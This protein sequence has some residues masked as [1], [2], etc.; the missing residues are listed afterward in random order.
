VRIGVEIKA[1][2]NGKTG[3]ARYLNEILFNLQSI[4]TSNE[5]FLF[6]FSGYSVPIMNT[7]WKQFLFPIKIPGILW[8][9]II[10]PL[11]CVVNKI[12]VLWAPEQT[13]P[14]LCLPR[15]KIVTT[16][17]DFTY[18][19]FPRTMR[20][21]NF[22]IQK[23]FTPLSCI[24]SHRIITVS[25]FVFKELSSFYPRAKAK[26]IDIPNGKPDWPMPTSY[27]PEKRKD[28]L[29]FN[30]NLEPRKNLINLLRAIELIKIKNRKTIE[31]HIAG[32][33]GWKQALFEKY[34]NDSPIRDNIRMLGF[35]DD[36]AL[37]SEYYS[38]KALVYPSL[39]EGFGLPVLEAL[40]CDCLV[41][42]S[43]GTVM[44]E[45]AREC[46]LYFNPDD[47]GDIAGKI[48]SL[49]QPGFDRALFLAGK[50]RI[51]DAYGWRKTAASIQAVFLSTR[52][53]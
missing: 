38:C 17:H 49:Y 53:L 27:V 24:K 23:L 46:A 5:Y 43:Q 3:I 29:F 52:G 8:Q 31:L 20:P 34:I 4:D 11:L 45:I 12:D 7:A 48:L 14:L 51:L 2:K 18:R 37:R 25:G 42:T 9:Q 50:N 32:P 40:C 33:S 30:G 41:L 36:A 19:R 47:P 13:C 6:G 16:I 39:Y 21:V 22:I 15:T 26:S 35:L 1:L 10:L 44:E 28:F